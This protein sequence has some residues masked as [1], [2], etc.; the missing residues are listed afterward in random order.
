ML[1]SEVGQDRVGH[2]LQEWK[3][4]GGDIRVKLALFTKLVKETG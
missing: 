3:G 2:C 1:K 4:V